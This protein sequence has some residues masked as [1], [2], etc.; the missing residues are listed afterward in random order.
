MFYIEF[1]WWLKILL[2][3]K[4]G[5]SVRVYERQNVIRELN[6]NK[7]IFE[8]YQNQFIIYIWRL[9]NADLTL[10]D[11]SFII[12]PFPPNILPKRNP[13]MAYSLATVHPSL[14][15]IVII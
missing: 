5:R 7:N 10:I 14:H 8:V 1:S 9:M 12:L 2:W 15:S 13:F 3:M 4:E 11:D 6:P